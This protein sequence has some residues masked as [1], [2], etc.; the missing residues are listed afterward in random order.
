MVKKF[1]PKQKQTNEERKVNVG[2]FA[3]M[4]RA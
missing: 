3:F 4:Y 2:Y 1:G